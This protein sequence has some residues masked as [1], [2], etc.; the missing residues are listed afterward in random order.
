MIIPEKY[1]LDDQME[2]VPG[3]S[4]FNMMG[5]ERVDTQSF[6][7]QTGPNDYYLIILDTKSPTL[8]SSN[9]IEISNTGYM[10]WPGYNNVIVN[11]DGFEDTYVINRIYKF[12]DYDQVK[13]IK[14]RLCGKAR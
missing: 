4:R 8:P 11:D 3:I 9:T 10:V 13:A 7:L 14:A 12:K 2:N 5:W 1:N 6:I